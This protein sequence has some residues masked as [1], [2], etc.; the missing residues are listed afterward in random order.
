MSNKTIIGFG[1]CDIWNNQGQGTL[2]STLI[3]P[4]ITKTSSTY[5]LKYSI[6]VHNIFVL[7]FLK[8]YL[9]G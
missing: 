6:D 4:D 8:F 9:Q 7:F 1:F 5:C 3:I 2:A